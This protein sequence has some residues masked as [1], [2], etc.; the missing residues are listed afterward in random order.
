[1]EGK[2]PVK[3]Y[4]PN[5]QRLSIRGG[6]GTIYRLV[7]K[8]K[9]IGDISDVHRFREAFV[10]AIYNHFGRSYRVTAHAA[11]EVVLDD[12]EPHLRT[13]GTFWTVTQGAEVLSGIRYAENLA[14]CYG[15][16]TVY[17]NFLGF[18]LIDTRSGEVVD[19]ERNQLA[20]SSKVR[21]FWLELADPLIL[22]D[23]TD[24][25][26]LF[27]VEQL[28]RIGAPF[29]VPCDRHDLGTFTTLNRPPT[30]YLYET[31]PGGIGVAE[32]ALELWP[33]VVETAIGIADRCACKHGCPSC[34]VPHGCRPASRNR[35][36][37][38]RSRSL[39]GSWTSRRPPHANGLIRVPTRGSHCHR[40]G[41]GGLGA[42]EPSN[43]RLQ[44]MASS[45]R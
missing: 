41:N 37:S 34:L 27:G 32:K 39:A 18:K 19:E 26:D 25:R 23:G 15:R 30:V 35:R 10:G 31:V 20:R 38:R 36:S 8:G 22:G 7:S 21:G 16:L 40:C 2:K 9:E 29:V 5:Y 42:R 44:R 14:A 17:E 3:G 1:M 11:G 12:A 45:R 43:N 33:T 6:S 24:V 4:G 28:L 13:E